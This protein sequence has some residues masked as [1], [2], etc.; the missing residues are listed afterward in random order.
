MKRIITQ[1]IIL[2]AF[3]FSTNTSS[4]QYC[5]TGLYTFGCGLDYFQ[6][7][8]TTGGTTNITNNGTGCTGGGY[9]YYPTMTHSAI[10]NTTVNYSFTINPTFSENVKIW[11]DWNSN[12]NYTDPGEQVYAGTVAGNSTTTGNFTVPVTATPG[13]TR[14]RIRLVYGSANTAFTACS[15]ESEGEIEEYN[16]M[17]IAATPCSGQPTA[18]TVVMAGSCPTTLNLTGNTLAGNM[19]VQWQ[20]RICGN[21]WVNIGGANNYNYAISTLGTPTEFRAFVICST[22]GLSDT[23][24]AVYVT[25]LIP[26]YCASGASSTIDEEIFSVTVNGVTNALACNVTAPGP[27]SS[28]NRYSNFTTLGPL[29]T[30]APG[31]VVPFSIVEDECDGSPYYPHGIAMWIDFNGDGDFLD[32]G[33]Q[34]YSDPGTVTG[35][36]TVTG[37]F[38][39]PSNA[40][41]N[42]VTGMRVTAAE[43]YAGGSLTSCL[44]Y[45]YG[46]TEDYLVKIGYL[47]VVTG[48]GVYC[49]GDNVTLTANTPGLPNPKYLWLGPNGQFVDTTASINFPNIQPSSNGTYTLNVLSYKCGNQGIPD[50]VARKVVSIYVNARPGKPIVA[51][52]ITYCEGDPFDSIA[53]HGQNLK[54]YSVPTGGIPLLTPPVINTNVFGSATYYVSQTVNNCEGP[55]AAVTI[56]VV[57][58][59]PPPIV[60]SPVGYCQGDPA[61]P[62]SALGQNIRWYSVPTGGV[63]SP[64]VPVPTTSAQGTFTWYATQTI[65]GCESI[66]V[67]V[68]VTVSYKP[69]A[70]I[71]TN[72]PFVC[73]YDT[74]TLTYFGNALPDASF[75]WT[76]PEGATVEDGLGQ[77]PLLVRFDSAGTQRVT[78]SVSNAGCV[79]PLATVDIPVRMAPLFGLDLQDEACQGDIV[80]LAVNYSTTGIDTYEWFGFG[81]GEMIYGSPTAG[82]YG[83]KWNT[84]GVKVIDVQ[85]TDEGCK[86]LPFSDTITIHE[87]PNAT[88]EP[89]K[90]NICTGDTVEFR[91]V[92]DE[93]NSYRWEPHQFFGASHSYID[94]G[95]ID[96][97]RYVTLHVTNRFNCTASDSVL[98]SAK[99][100]CEI[101]F[102]NAFTPN[103]DGRNDLFRAITVGTHQITAFQ[104]QN[105]WGQVV[106]NSG[107]EFTGWDGTFNGTPQ[108]M[109]T[110]FYYVKYKCSDGN[111]YEDKGEVM[112][113]R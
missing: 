7:F 3:L 1:L 110:Y 77:G 31:A 4:G 44:A 43:G 105:R 71:L 85:A 59:A 25:N 39:V 46:E 94:S 97:S 22:S 106:F 92:Y 28:L 108:D 12:G 107:D 40:T 20:S 104:V 21:S 23:T 84:P 47:P 95:I 38:T 18:G 111:F 14:M 11:V 45:S 74:M 32:A 78:L 57:P 29:T 81:G 37:S 16:F 2:V 88:F 79:G 89:S 75:N 70:L 96:Y 6:S 101:Y 68:E 33:E 58:K 102:P 112:L 64:V 69:N 52:I 19:T 36:R 41:P 65:A 66:R 8:S 34:V 86:S 27:G 10:Q 24:N 82:P 100:C 15:P 42:I 76:M 63:G 35:P 80:N 50:T 67:P 61:T 90:N 56:N 54:W 26:C 17:V 91:G 98:I 30:M 13:L 93:G 53:I 73:Q 103:N 62:L 99:P 55:R 72:R 48:A 87:L 49:A 83:V 5:N 113:V 109:A 60:E 51:P 9:T